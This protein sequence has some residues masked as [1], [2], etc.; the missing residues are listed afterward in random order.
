MMKIGVD[1]DNTFLEF[2][3]F[4]AELYEVWFDKPIQG[5]FLNWD[6]IVTKT[7]FETSE[8]MIEWFTRAGGWRSMPYEKGAP[9]GLDRLLGA[10]HKVLFIT[11]RRGSAEKPTHDWHRESPWARPVTELLTGRTDKWFTDCDIY[12]DDSPD[13]IRGLVA[14]GKDTIIMDKPWNQDLDA[15]VEDNPLVFVVRA[16]NWHEI[17]DIIEEIAS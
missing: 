11:A 16:K 6:D 13:V 3:P 10:G 9:G 8:Q 15:L 5:P 7:H 17:T 4:W 1:L 12:I 2:Q 14:A